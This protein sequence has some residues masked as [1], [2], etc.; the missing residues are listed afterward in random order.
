MI[1]R[2]PRATL[3]PYTRLFRTRMPYCPIRRFSAI[4]GRLQGGVMNHVKRA[5]ANRDRIAKRVFWRLAE[6]CLVLVDRKS[7]RLNSSHANISYAV[8]CL[9]KKQTN[10][11]PLQ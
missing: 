6:V 2:P 7:T 4:K 5:G 3:F 1:R 8:F 11:K 9:Q 10:K